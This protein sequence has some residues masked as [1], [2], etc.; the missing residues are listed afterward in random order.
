MEMGLKVEQWVGK[1]SREEL[2]RGQRR[3]ERG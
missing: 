3:E 1:G 2:L